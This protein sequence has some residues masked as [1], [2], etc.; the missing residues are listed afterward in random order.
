MNIYRLFGMS[1][2]SVVSV[3]IS[4]RAER[5][6]SRQPSQGDS[7]YHINAIVKPDNEPNKAVPVEGQP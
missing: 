1:L 5:I 6:L 3:L 2:K 4:L 7:L